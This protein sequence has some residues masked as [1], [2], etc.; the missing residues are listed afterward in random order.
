[1]ART[2]ADDLPGHSGGGEERSPT[3]LVARFK[4]VLKPPPPPPPPPV[5]VQQFGSNGKG[6]P[7]SEINMLTT[8]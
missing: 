1:M 3:R 8:D 2:G 4:I 7:G 6:Q 5:A